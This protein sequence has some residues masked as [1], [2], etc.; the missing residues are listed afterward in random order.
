[1]G[2]L[3]IFGDSSIIGGGKL[4]FEA[5]LYTILDLPQRVA[6]YPIEQ[7]ELLIEIPAIVPALRRTLKG[8]HHFHEDGDLYPGPGNWKGS[9]L[10]NPDGSFGT[11]TVSSQRATLQQDLFKGEIYTSILVDDN[12]NFEASSGELIF[13][14]GTENQEVP[15]R[16]R[17]IPNSST[18]LIDPSYTFTKD[19][20]TGTVVNVLRS[21]TPYVPERSGEDLAVY[22]TSPSGAREIVEEI[23]Q[24]LKAAGI[25]I[26]FVVLAPEYKYILDNPYI[27][28]DDAPSC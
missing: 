11:F 3:E 28:E 1:V 27:S 25:V 13:G 17:G 18:I 24:T 4:G 9:F 10:F 12:S 15:V 22:L 14:F 6:V 19:H 2:K 16:F 23:L 8:S 21:Q 7:N 26:R 20:P 5:G